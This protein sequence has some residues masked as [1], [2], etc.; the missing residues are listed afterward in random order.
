M[1][2]TPQHAPYEDVVVGEPVEVRAYEREHDGM[3]IAE[4]VYRDDTFGGQLDPKGLDPLALKT[5][6]DRLVTSLCEL[7]WNEVYAT[8]EFR[9]E[10]EDFVARADLQR[11]WEKL[12]RRASQGW[13]GSV[14]NPEALD[15][16]EA[17]TSAMRP[18]P[19]PVAAALGDADVAELRLS[20]EEM[21]A[22][23]RGEIPDSLIERLLHARS[24]ENLLDSVA[25]TLRIVAEDAGR[26]DL[27]RAQ[28]ELDVVRHRFGLD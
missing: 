24:T 12:P 20:Q 5:E 4:F 25:E 10:D 16:S 2:R 26:E 1:S 7:A 15:G 19:D 11:P 23:T 3:I 21:A 14:S 22:L 18:E 27:A 6:V 17:T 28:R 9:E 8:P 13:I